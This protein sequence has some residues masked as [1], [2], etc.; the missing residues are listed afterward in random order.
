[1]HPFST[2]WKTP[3]TESLG[4]GGG[5]VVDESAWIKD[6]TVRYE[7]LIGSNWNQNLQGFLTF[8][9][10]RERVHWEQMSVQYYRKRKKEIT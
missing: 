4:G 8:S 5:M 6:W 7:F 9:G 10:G 2:S 1:M 3:E